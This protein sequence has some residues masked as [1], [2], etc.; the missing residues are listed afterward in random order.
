MNRQTATVKTNA[1]LHYNITRRLYLW[2]RF[3]QPTNRKI[4]NN[5]LYF[6]DIILQYIIPPSQRIIFQIQQTKFG[7]QDKQKFRNLKM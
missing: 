2:F 3:F 4:I 6:L 7:I 5:L 1:L